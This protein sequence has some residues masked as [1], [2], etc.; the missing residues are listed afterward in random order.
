MSILTEPDAKHSKFIITK[1]PND[2]R[3]YAGLDKKLEIKKNKLK[4]VEHKRRPFM[5]VT[6]I[7]G[8][9]NPY[10]DSL[11]SLVID[12]YSPNEYESV[13]WEIQPRLIEYLAN[14]HNKMNIKIVLD[15]YASAVALRYKNTTDL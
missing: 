6:R 13:F 15:L 9:Y 5:S 11:Y 1:I 12:H 8:P 7:K 14:T 2:Y 4:H 3:L 10:V